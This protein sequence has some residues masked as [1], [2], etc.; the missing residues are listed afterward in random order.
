MYEL[1]SMALIQLIRVTFESSGSGP[2]K[3]RQQYITGSTTFKLSA[4][5]PLTSSGWG[6]QVEPSG[7]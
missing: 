3:P 6:A 2:L 1:L 4:G 7:N 5:N